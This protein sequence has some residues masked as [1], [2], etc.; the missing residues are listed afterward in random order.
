MAVAVAVAVG[1]GWRAAEDAEGA[2]RTAAQN[3]LE[4]LPRIAEQ[5]Q[6]EEE[7][8]GRDSS[9]TCVRINNALTYI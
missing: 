7:E 2:A 1:R 3:K 9:A 5:Q 6:E 4:P 8:E